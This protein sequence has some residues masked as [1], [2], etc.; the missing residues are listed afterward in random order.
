MAAGDLSGARAA[1]TD[2]AV[3]ARSR[4]DAELLA[5]AALGFGAGRGGFEVPLQDPVHVQLLEEALVALGPTPS[6][7]RAWVLARLSVA[8]SFLDAEPRRR[9][10]SDEAV[11]VAR[12]V[13]DRSALGH[14][15]AAHCDSIAGPDWCEVRLDESTEI[16]RLGQSTGDPHLELLGRRLR[17]VALLEV[18]DVGEADLEIRRFAHVAEPLRQPLYLWYVPLWRGMRSLMRGDLAEAARECAQAEAIGA[19]HSD[20]AR[21]LTFTQWWVRQRYEGRF[22]ARRA[23]RWRSCS[24]GTAAGPPVTAAPRAVAALQVGDRAKARVLLEQWRAAGLADRPRDSEWLPE[25]AQLA[26]AAV[27]TGFD[28]LAALLYEQLGPMPTAAASRASA[29]RAPAR[30]RGTWPCWPASSVTTPTPSGY[31][32]LGPARPTGGSAWWATRHP[33]PATRSRFPS[34]R[35][36][37]GERPATLACEGATWAVTFAGRTRRLRDSKG[38]RDWPPCWPGRSRRCTAWS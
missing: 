9:A 33:W 8:L 19:A 21:V 24:G 6:R 13:G 1:F 28:D 31:D 16:V 3:V 30:S 25:T 4:G 11:D 34:G 17:L 12:Q 27:L 35:T 37:D 2:A 5:T 22:A 15:L 7:L 10:L 38:L 20:N 26:E 18:G 32:A 23:R 14:A 29:P 36:I